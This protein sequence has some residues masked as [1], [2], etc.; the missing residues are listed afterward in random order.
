MQYNGRVLPMGLPMFRRLL[1]PVAFLMIVFCAGFSIAQTAAPV[2]APWTKYP[3]RKYERFADLNKAPAP[4]ASEEKDIQD[5][6]EET[7]RLSAEQPRGMKHLLKTPS[8]KSEPSALEKM[9]SARIVD[10]VQQFGYD[11]FGV[12]DDSLEAKL[13]GAGGSVMPMG[14]V[15]DD[16]TLSSGDELEIVFTG[17]KTGREVYKI[18]SR[19]VLIIPD[20]PPIPAEGRTIGQVRISVAAAASSL[21]NTE[22]YVALSSV[23]QIGVLV[24]GHV[25]QP[26]RQTLTVFHTLLDA[27][28]TAGGVQKTGSLRQIKLVR[29]GRSMM[30]DLYALLMHGSTNIDLRLKDGD[31][32]IIPAIG[33]TVAVAGEVKRPGI[34]EILPAMSG[35]L[36]QPEKKSEK[37][38]LDEMLEMGG[39]VMAPGENRFL[40][41][42]V[43]SK[44]EEQVSEVSDSFDPVF[45]DGSIL[46][47]SKGEEKRAGL[48]ELTGNTRKP[49]LHA[50]DKNA[51]LSKLI[52]SDD[53]PG[54]DAY[55]LIGVIERKDKDQM[56]RELID[57]PLRLVLKGKYDRKL[58]D[59]DIVHLFSLE[60]MRNLAT[61][62]NEEKKDE[63]ER[64]VGSRDDEDVPPT[65]DDPQI[66][67]FLRERS[68]YV[69]GAVRMPGAYPVSEGTTMDTVLAV[70]G[71]LTLEANTANI[72]VT[73][74]LQ[75]KKLQTQG[76]SGT[77]R[78]QINFQDTGPQDVMIGAGDAIR[79]NQKFRKVGEKSVLVIGEVHNP[80]RYDLLPG[81]KV[82]DLL[83]RA[84]GLTEQAYA[85]GAIFSRETERIAE[86]ARF[87][88]QAAGIKRSISA[89]LAEDDKKVDTG[90]IEEARALA[91]ELEN[92]QGVGRI[93]VEA[94]PAA[95]K[96][97]PELDMLLESG[98][99]LY[100][101]K[102]NLS[103]R[104]SGEVLSP[105][106]L[107]FRE[108]KAPLD[109][110]H[111]AGG[112][113]F[114]AD[115][116]RTFVLYPDGSAQPLQVSA[117]NHKATFIPPG[118][119]VIVPRD[120][121]PFD[122]IE[123]AK[124]LSQ[125]LSN[126]AVTAIFVDD[127]RDGD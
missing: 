6:E 43:T 52:N 97:S 105:A 54:L 66:E 35:M 21:Y 53:V 99:R 39:G 94:D 70:A 58:E 63:P 25:R 74:D 60:Q 118:S 89:A 82:S 102:R 41:L 104:V 86:E 127:V 88:A 1:V 23:R 67:S 48:V 5:F 96:V 59:G 20:F 64:E 57:F 14:E 65:I 68:V 110:I 92:A 98:D 106:S 4:V 123:G 7:E 12:P 91:N 26:G 46:M 95:L 45:G 100:I 49:G 62:A 122:F 16:F 79:V 80:G 15:Q 115:T 124:D 34:F 42:R 120:P 61:G 114:N 85:D 84:G 17:Q 56:T 117:W 3:T 113:T 28:M 83:A 38:G 9:Y 37:L 108:K 40:A 119:T 111:E 47:V 50:L 81:D 77:Q 112:F 10:E 36:S 30:V 51:S 44:G 101:P 33:P 29:G 18:N 22:T 69:R 31:R 11:M 24:I 71:G 19:G 78:T 72:E 2:V 87:R 93:T 109:Y 90:K 103:V 8:Q 55:P 76:R 125:I 73:S 107:M 116:D 27:L 126:L 121:K 32:I 13:D 75:G